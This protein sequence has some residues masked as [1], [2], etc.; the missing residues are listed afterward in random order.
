MKYVLSSWKMYPTVDQA[1]ASFEA[2][3]AGL[4]ERA[5]RGTVLPR[6]IL[7]PPFLSL[8]PFAALVDRRV[9]ALGAQNC[10]WEA[11]GAYTGEISPRM[12]QGLVDYV[13]VGHSE[14]RA[15]GETDEQVAWKVA[16]VA[17]HGLTPILLVGEDDPG[18]D[19]ILLSEQRLRQGLSGVD[20]TGEPVLVVYEP[21]WA[22]GTDE[23]A[24]TSHVRRSVT[25]LKAVL[26]DMGATEPQVLYG[27]SVNDDNVEAL[28]G[29]GVLD[30]VGA[31]RASLDAAQF[32]RLI[33]RVAQAM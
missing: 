6:V 16:A 29:L 10:H 28:A 14:R 30:G 33:D 31:G 12:L 8:V 26:T 4:Q 25:H 21:T 27:G 1:Q 17:Q 18:E 3:Q 19:A 7:C 20:V 2:I 23:T 15:A 13:L 32:L 9:L 24:S 11:E 5:E 22:I